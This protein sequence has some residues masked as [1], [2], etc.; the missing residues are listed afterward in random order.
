MKL[1]TRTLVAGLMLVAGVAIAADAADPTVKAWQTL[2]D[3]NGGAAKALGGMASG[4]VPFDGAAA[5][6]AKQTLIANA[7]DIP[8]KFQTQAADPASKASPDIWA[9]WDDFAA[10][11]KALG[12]AASMLDVS[13]LDTLKAGMGAVGGACKDCHSKYKMQ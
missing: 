3:G 9:N 2:M 5:E 6:A 4:E 13:S 12:D 1:K 7:A 11:A 8:V 10:K